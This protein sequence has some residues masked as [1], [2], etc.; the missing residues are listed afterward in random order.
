MIRL[1]DFCEKENITSIFFMKMDIEGHEIEALMGA[2]KLITEKKVQ[3]IQ[4]EF[5]PA[6]IGSRTYFFDFW[7]LLNENYH[8]SRI[9]KDGLFPILEYNETEE[10]FISTN[11]FCELKSNWVCVFD[12]RLLFNITTVQVKQE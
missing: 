9:L 11:F 1:D 6:N 12:F 8:I 5:G 3:Y 10:I 7:K 2:G 4:F